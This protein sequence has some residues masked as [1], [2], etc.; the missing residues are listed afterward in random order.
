MKGIAMTI[1]TTRGHR[2]RKRLMRT[3]ASSIAMTAAT[4]RGH[5]MGKDTTNPKAR[6]IAMMVPARVP[7]M[8]P[9]IFSQRMTISPVQSRYAL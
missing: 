4:T 6:I 8:T 7:I 5:P 3:R 2:A 9:V 1:P